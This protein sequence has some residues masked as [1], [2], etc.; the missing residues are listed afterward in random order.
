[1]DILVIVLTAWKSQEWMAEKPKEAIMLNGVRL[2]NIGAWIEG[3]GE[4]EREI[5]QKS[6][7]SSPWLAF[8]NDAATPWECNG[9]TWIW[10]PNPQSTFP[11]KTDLYGFLI[12]SLRL[13]NPILDRNTANHSRHNWTYIGVAKCAMKFAFLP[14]IVQVSSLQCSY[15]W[16]CWASIV[17]AKTHQ[18]YNIH[19]YTCIYSMQ[20]TH[21]HQRRYDKIMISSFFGF[22]I[23]PNCFTIC[24]Q[25]FK[26]PGMSGVIP[27]SIARSPLLQ[28]P[29]SLEMAAC[30]TGMPGMGKIIYW[31]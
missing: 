8:S 23:S 19:Q 30:P 26:R 10:K 7:V 31:G 27:R 25:Y 13:H 3:A 11:I 28:S 22:I 29:I 4:R 1:M 21:I 17:S 16:R 24:I 2:P 6:T 15:K 14:G 9:K 12:F 18:V 20:Y 5:S